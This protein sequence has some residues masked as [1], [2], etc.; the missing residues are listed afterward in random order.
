[1][2]TIAFSYNWNNK[3]DC[4]YFTTLRLRNSKYKVGLKYEILEKGVKKKTV[5]CMAIREITM[6]QISPF[7]A[8]VDTGYS[9]EETKNL[10]KRMYINSKINWDN[11]LLQ[12]ILLKTI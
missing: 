1:M 10:L 7:I 9:V 6:S 11:Q 2:D 3:L 12:L 5:E 8:G 4:K